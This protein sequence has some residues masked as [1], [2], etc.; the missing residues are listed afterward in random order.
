MCGIVGIVAKS[1]V[2]QTIF[3]ALTVLQH[4][5]QDAAGMVTCEGN[6]F[7][8]RKDNGLVNEVFR[9]RHMKRL[10]GNVGIGHVRYP[11]AGSSSSAEAQ[12]FYVNS[13][14]GIALAHNGNLTNAE[15]VAEQMFRAD[16][17]HINTTSDSE[18]LLNVLAHELQL[19]GKLKPQADDMFAAVQRVHERC[20]G[21]YAAV[22]LITGYG[23]LAFRDPHGIRPLIYG[24]R[25]TK[26]GTEYMVA[27]ESVA[28][29]ISG[30]ERVRD[31]APGEAIYI[32]MDGNVFT[33]QCAEKTKLAPCL[34][35]YVYLARPDSIMD[36]VNVHVS[37]MRMGKNLA[38]KIIRERPDHDIDV[39]IPI[40]DTSRTSAMEMAK[41]LGV[42]F[43]E[44]FIKNRYIG[45]TFIMPGQVQRKKSVRRKLNPIGMEFKDKVV[46]LVDDSI[47]R[48]TTSSQIV[49]MA[50]DVGA[51]KVYFAS[52]A[53]PVKYPNVY[54][55]D[56]PAAEELI[57][58]GRTDEEIGKKIGCDWMIYQELD[59][60]K[61]SVSDGNPK[62]TA[63]DTCV[64]DGQYVAGDIDAGYLKRLKAARKDSAKGKNKQAGSNES[65]NLCS[66]ID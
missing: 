36:E 45:R 61:K 44:G 66:K 4:R 21:G 23:M 25:E 31:I 47:V 17:R 59:D 43:R 5:G 33:Q 52:A 15:D 13:P 49:Q 35:E 26:S 9:T 37:R 11:T 12:P 38:D 2:N 32:D 7:F 1:N 60:L 63:F 34:F 51:K 14:Y 30:F 8:L 3:D 55:I 19:Q 6:R 56:M 48:G 29:D 24:K 57:A 41:E 54:G 50:R 64:F 53:P 16:L 39:I 62:I 10:A 46:M 58:H 18:V 42:T 40:P 20:K 22:A 65:S 27:S 28:L